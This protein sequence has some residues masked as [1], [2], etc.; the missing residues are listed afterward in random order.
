L[1]YFVTVAEELNF[2]RAAERLRTAGP[3]LSQ[4]IKALERDLKGA[5]VRPR[6]PLGR[7]HPGWHVATAL[8]TCADRAGRRITQACSWVGGLGSGPHRVC[9]LVSD[10]L[11]GA[12]RGG[13]AAAD[14]H[15]GDAVAHPGRPRRRRQP[16]P[17]HLLGA[18]LGPGDAVAERAPGGG[19]AAL[20][21][22]RRV[23]HRAG[24]CQ[25]RAR[26]GGRR[27]R[28]LVVLEPL[29]RAVRGRHRGARH[30]DRRRRCH[31]ADVLR[32]RPPVAPSGPK[33]PQGA[34]RPAAQDLVRRPVVAPTPLWTWSLVW[35]RGEDN[36]TV[37]A[38]I[39]AFTRDLGDLGLDSAAVWLPS[40]DPHQDRRQRGE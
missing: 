26:A 20:R 39:E 4:Q 21:P 8:C 5:I 29:R 36:A 13:G 24:G 12:G 34:G 10:R 7:A 17:G 27:C 31:R 40:D 14:R 37:Q 18:E 33:Q 9:E 6:P 35:R 38:V 23:G 3:L 25:G 32:A 15:L 28:Q 19:R 11:V 2:G 1:R 16:G 30:A 22:V